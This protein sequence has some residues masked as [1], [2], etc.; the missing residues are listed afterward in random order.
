VKDDLFTGCVQTVQKT[1]W[2]TKDIP[3]PGDWKGTILGG[4]RTEFTVQPAPEG[5][6]VA[7]TSLYC[8]MAILPNSTE[9]ALNGIAQKEKASIYGCEGHDIFHSW[10]SNKDG[11]DTGEAT[12]ANTDVF[13]DVFEHVR[14]KGAYLQHDWTVKVDADCVFV[15]DR[16]RYHLK[17]L[18]PPAYTP[19]YIKNNGMDP[20]L[21]NNG[22][23][24]AIEIFS[25]KAMR[26]Y[27]DNAEG[28]KN[29]FG[30]NCGEDGFFKGCMDAIG[31]GF[32]QDDQIFFPDRHSGSCSQENHVA[33]HPLKKPEQWQK[34]WDLI[35]H[36]A[37]W[38]N[39]R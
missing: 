32:M 23:L 4:G 19:I 3:I 35:M 6:A 10:W 22:F 8:I 34:C 21:G 26:Y 18:K 28:C 30:F 37:G 36:R 20:G 38:Q 25:T 1:T 5:A 17:A 11:W 12:L 29:Y 15:P 27:F 33:F 9:E 24:G 7:G 13:I 14:R 2:V 39:Q 16:L 31:V